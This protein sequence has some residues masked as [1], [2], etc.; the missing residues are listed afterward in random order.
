MANEFP[1]LS[2]DIAS[3][4]QFWQL[5]HPGELQNKQYSSQFKQA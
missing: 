5:A 4:I 1:G 3:N 2:L